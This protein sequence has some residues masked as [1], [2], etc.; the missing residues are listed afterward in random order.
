M[1]R[2][3]FAFLIVC[4]LNSYSQV[5][6]FQSFDYYTSTWGGD[7]GFQVSDF[8]KKQILITIDNRKDLITMYD[9]VLVELE[10]IKYGDIDKNSFQTTY[11]YTC[12]NNINVE[13]NVAIT[14][15][16]K[17]KNAYWELGI[18]YSDHLVTTRMI[19]LN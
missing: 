13:C 3:L 19:P 1:K 17:F 7:E 9:N 15:P 16:T 18:H 4:S 2:I 10:I 12:I 14:E 11:W 6:N 5:L 8:F